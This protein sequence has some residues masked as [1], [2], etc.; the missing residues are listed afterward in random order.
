M[1]RRLCRFL[2]LLAA[3][4]IV[5]AP[6]AD[7][8]LD[9]SVQGRE[10]E[11]IVGRILAPT[12][13]TAAL[14]TRLDE[15]DDGERSRSSVPFGLSAVV[16]LPLLVFRDAVTGDRKRNGGNGF[17]RRSLGSRAPPAPLFA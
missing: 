16:L 14:P 4:T 6:R 1:T 8:H 9:R 3:A 7:V 10:A 17:G 12:L 11:Q 13:S 15:Q 2:A 5:L